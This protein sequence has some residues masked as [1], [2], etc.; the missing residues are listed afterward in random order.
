MG[1]KFRVCDLTIFSI[2]ESACQVDTPLKSRLV[3]WVV[4]F[5]WSVEAWSLDACIF[6]SCAWD[7]ERAPQ[8]TH[9]AV[10]VFAE[11][12]V[13]LRC[14]VSVFVDIDRDV[15]KFPWCESCTFWDYDVECEV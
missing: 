8:W 2:L 7:G 9:V 10:A 11:L 15:A 6:Q 14:T 5:V 13:C 3:E 4:N 12:R 1:R